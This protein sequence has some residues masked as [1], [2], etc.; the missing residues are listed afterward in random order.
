MKIPARGL[1]LI[2]LIAVIAA[3]GTTSAVVLPESAVFQVA[4][5]SAALASL[6][7]AASSAMA[8]NQAGC[9]VSGQR[10]VP[11]QCT[12]ISNC[13][14][15]GA[16]LLV[17]LPAAYRVDDLPLGG[18]GRAASCRLTQLDNGAVASFTGIAAGH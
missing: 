5:E 1:S 8:I 12:P 13:A 17:E 9:Q 2:E 16:L 4:A 15:V 11:D 3:I 6:A 14:Q 7:G 10:A 18:N